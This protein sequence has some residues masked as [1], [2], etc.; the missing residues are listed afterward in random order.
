MPPAVPVMIG[1]VWLVCHLVAAMNPHDLDALDEAVP[2][3]RKTL[4]SFLGRTL[5]AEEY[6][7]AST[8][9][10]YTP[11]L[12]RVLTYSLTGHAA[13]CTPSLP[14]ALH[15]LRRRFDSRR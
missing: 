7:V 2:L 14:C 3:T 1:R 6:V 9:E 5:T 12:P 10:L 15:C 11:S 8:A 4:Q 13:S